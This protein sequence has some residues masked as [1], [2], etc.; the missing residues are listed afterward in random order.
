MIK[1]FAVAAVIAVGSTSAW[2]QSPQTLFWDTAPHVTEFYTTPAPSS[3]Y[4]STPTYY[5]YEMPTRGMIPD[6]SRGYIPQSTWG[7]PQQLPCTI[8]GCR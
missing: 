4:G 6:V 5:R 1:A 3:M 7:G 8:P 2:A